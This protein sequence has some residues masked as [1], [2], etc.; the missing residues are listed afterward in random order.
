VVIFG[1]SIG[2]VLRVSQAG[3]AP[4]RLTT[5]DEVHGELGHMRPWFLPDGRH[6]LYVLRTRNP[7]AAGIYLATL[8][9]PERKRLAATNQAGAYAT[10]AAGS[11]N[12]HLLFLREGTLM[13]LPLDARR[14]EPAGEP[15]P[16]AEQVGSA[17]AMGFFSVSANGV[18]AYRNGFAGGI[19]SQLVWFDR[20]GKSLG[21]LGP[22]ATYPS[23]PTLSRDGNRAAVDQLDAGPAGRREVWV[24]DVARGVPTRVTF[25]S[26]NISPAWSPNGTR[27]VFVSNRGGPDGIYQKDSGGT[28]KE[29]LLLQSGMPMV[30]N[31][32]SLDGRYLLYSATSEK[33]GSDLWV[34][35]GG[36][37]TPPGGKP[38]PYLREPYNEKQG[39][40]SPDGRSIAYSSDETGS[41]Q[42][43][44]QS[45]PAGAGKFRVSTA[46]GTQPRWRRDG[47]EIYYISADG[48]LTAVD[49]KTA[50]R[51]EAGA[52]QALFDPRIP[53]TALAESYFH[54]DVAADGKR[55]LVSSVAPDGAGPAPTPI[56]VIVNWPAALKH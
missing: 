15:F 38:V 50:P 2:G 7:E 49:V 27:L 5:L 36:A 55:F 52:P 1:T 37:G 26:Q 21:T 3:G 31:D 40:F 8:D 12:G 22:R 30:L 39:Q 51:Y 33:T 45:F 46:G 25:D 41:Y 10:P 29:E 34:L 35:P 6:F 24:L 4:A 56:T 9:G 18:L 47:K 23:G 54:Y 13:A 20:Q 48:K 19:G 32:W 17:L 28:G 44:V 16:V 42:V 14:F 53:A 43:Y 11:Q